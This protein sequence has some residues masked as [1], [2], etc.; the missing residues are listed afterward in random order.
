MEAKG[1]AGQ[2]GDLK[3][4]RWAFHQ[5]CPYGQ[6]AFFPG[7]V[8]DWEVVKWR[9]RGAEGWDG[10]PSEG[11]VRPHL[12]DPVCLSAHPCPHPLCPGMKRGVGVAEQFSLGLL[13]SLPQAVSVCFL[14]RAGWSSVNLIRDGLICLPGRSYWQGSLIPR[15]R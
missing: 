11:L 14:Q 6:D 8:K 9:G 10:L 12:K 7:Q 1:W 3:R 15:Y 4:V 2:G 13:I 5:G